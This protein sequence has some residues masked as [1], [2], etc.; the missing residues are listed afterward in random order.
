MRKYSGKSIQIRVEFL[1][2]GSLNTKR[3]SECWS[4]SKY[5]SKLPLHFIHE[6]S[7]IRKRKRAVQYYII[8]VDLSLKSECEVL[9][10]YR[11]ESNQLLSNKNKMYSLSAPDTLWLADSKASPMIPGNI[12]STPLRD[13]LL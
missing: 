2:F 10:H 5:Q 9:V 1:L 4:W 6:E 3:N 13:A 8:S 7:E 11:F 12:V